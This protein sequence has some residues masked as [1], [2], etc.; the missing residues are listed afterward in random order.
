[1]QGVITPDWLNDFIVKLD[2]PEIKKLKENKFHGK[3]EINFTDGIP[4]NYNMTM[5]RKAKSIN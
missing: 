4:A 1:M 2:Y 5:N 3:L